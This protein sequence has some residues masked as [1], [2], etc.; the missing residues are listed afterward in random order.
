MASLGLQEFEGR[1]TLSDIV[2]TGV[3]S[4]T[5]VSDLNSA[6]SVTSDS[7]TEDM[8][9]SGAS[10]KSQL[11]PHLAYR[12][13]SQKATVGAS[14]PSLKGKE[15]D[16]GPAPV[17]VLPPH[18]ARFLSKGSASSSQ[19]ENLPSTSSVAGSEVESSA[20]GESHDQGVRLTGRHPNYAASISTATT[21]RQEREEKS[22][23]Q[24]VSFNAWDSRGHQHSAIKSPTVMSSSTSTV[25]T[26]EP[27][28]EKQSDRGV[29]SGPFVHGEWPTITMKEPESRSKGSKW[30][31]A[32]EVSWGYD[33]LL[34]YY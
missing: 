15:V 8:S 22:K 21:V 10:V 23:S 1:H 24:Q 30:P 9:V 13:A 16:R 7:N 28:G 34:E 33:A 26:G 3:G 12:V 18:L 27:E 5:S 11:P 20:T 2:P 25:S 6:A 29:D 19:K 31:K 17:G 14:L 32:S 4:L